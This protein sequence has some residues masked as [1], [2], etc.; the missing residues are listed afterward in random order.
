MSGCA[1]GEIQK[2]QLGD[3]QI[4][5]MWTRRN[6]NLKTRSVSTLRDVARAAGVSIPTASQALNGRA[7][8]SRKT[9]ARVLQIASR[10]RYTPHSAARQLITGRADSI[11]VVA[12]SNM[13]GIFSDR[14]Y[15][16][17]LTGAGSVAENVGYRMLVAPPLGSTS[18]DPQV[19]RMVRGREVDGVLAVG[20]VANAWIVEMMETEM[21]V[22]LVDNKFRGV[23]APAVLNDD[24]W[25][26]VLATRHLAE[27]GHRRI[28][29][30]GAVNNEWWARETRMG[31]TYGLRQVGLPYDPR[32]AILVANEIEAARQ[33]T[34]PLLTLPHRPSAIFAGS[35]KIAIGVMRAAREC[36]L[37]IP[38][39]LSVVGT[40]DTDFAMMTDPPLTTVNVHSEEM[41]RRAAEILLDLV[42]G[43]PVP[44]STVIRP[45]LVVRATSG[46][47]PSS[48]LRRGNRS[49]S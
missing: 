38:Q 36:R 19:L 7:G 25:G 34:L 31:Y 47:F 42:R 35:G 21:P 6:R 12:G 30:V 33:G 46:P 16:P 13:S 40:G 4:Q 29:F 28:A 39:D 23:A 11:A 27:L 3:L 32:W 26:A 9:R 2:A 37:T 10:L 45:D 17:I 8:V 24:A 48:G 43:V 22:V 44:R 20:I 18:G 1:V 41:G 15:R 5:P 49:P 14:F